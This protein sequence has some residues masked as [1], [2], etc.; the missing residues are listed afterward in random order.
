VHTVM[1]LLT[2]HYL[3]DTSFAMGTLL[4]GINYLEC[5]LLEVCCRKI[6]A[7]TNMDET[8][9]YSYTDEHLTPYIYQHSFV[10]MKVIKA[11]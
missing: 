5:R 1:N 8:Q 4:H 3:S 10:M 6:H 9:K 11:I 7:F 2:P